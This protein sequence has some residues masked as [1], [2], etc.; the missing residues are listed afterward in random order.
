MR[1]KELSAEQRLKLFFKKISGFR[2]SGV[3]DERWCGV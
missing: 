1:L 2:E 3:C